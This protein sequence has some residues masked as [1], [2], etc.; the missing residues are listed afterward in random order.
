MPSQQSIR[1]LAEQ[2]TS[3]GSSDRHRIFEPQQI[4]NL[5]PV[6]HSIPGMKNV[7]TSIDC[8][9]YGQYVVRGGKTIDVH[10][11][12]TIFVTYNAQT[13]PDAMKEL[14]ETVLADFQTR[15]GSAFNITN[16]EIPPLPVPV[17]E[18]KADSAVFYRGTDMFRSMTAHER[19]RYDIKSQ[20][21]IAAKNIDS[22]RR[23]LPARYSP[24]GGFDK[25]S[26][27]LFSGRFK[28]VR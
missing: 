18:R 28:G 6:D 12:Y 8:Y 16:V 10:Q 21:D 2:A 1:Y 25:V 17:K 22:I 9:V 27:H 26:K 14:R 13:H 24:G 20:R 7:S 5:K 15:Y 4:G 23:H 19:A 11:R 3:K